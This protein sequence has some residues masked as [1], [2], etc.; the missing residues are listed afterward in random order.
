M[1]RQNYQSTVGKRSFTPPPH[2]K[3]VSAA[4][5]QAWPRS[6]VSRSLDWYPRGRVFDSGILPSVD[7]H[8]E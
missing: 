6:S 3:R 2:S 8:S 7:V 1:A 4:P 5:E